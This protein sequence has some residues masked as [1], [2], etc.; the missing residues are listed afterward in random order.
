MI[1]GAAIASSR[2]NKNAAQAAPQQAAPAQGANDDA[3]AQLEKLADL[4][5]KGI[6]TQEEFDAKKKELLGL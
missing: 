2:S 6:L 3:I 1:M 5:D 4:K